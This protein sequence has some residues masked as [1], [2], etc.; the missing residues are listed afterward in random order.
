M[1]HLF[2]LLALR[3]RQGL[4]DPL[5]VARRHGAEVFHETSFVEADLEEAGIMVD[6]VRL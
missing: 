5:D 1:A 3:R 6:S 4:P 2:G